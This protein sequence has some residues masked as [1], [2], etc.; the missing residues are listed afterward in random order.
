MG[1][2][3]FFAKLA[4]LD[5]EQR[6]KILWNLYWRG[7]AALRERI[8]GEL[9]PPERER[10]KRAVAAPPDPGLVLAEVSEFV[11]LASSGAYIA[12]DRRVSRTERSKWRVTFRR[13]ATEAQSALHAPDSD[14]AERAMELMIDLACDADGCFHSDNPLEAAKFVVSQAVSALWETV[15]DARG[16]AEFTARAVPQLIRWE[17]E[18]GWSNGDGKVMELERPLAEVLAS[19]LITPE[20]WSDFADAYLAELDRIAAAEAPLPGKGKKGRQSLAHSPYSA[21]SYARTRRTGD[22]AYWNSLLLEHLDEER[23]QRLAGHPAFGGTDADFLRAQAAQLRGD[24]DEARTLITKC[25]E[26]LPGSTQ[27]AEFAEEVGAEFPPRAREIHGRRRLTPSM[28]KCSGSSPSSSPSSSSGY[29]TG[30]S[31]SNA[32]QTG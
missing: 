28:S 3:E 24:L 15:L 29:S 5:A 19:M 32:T 11:E 22:L 31:P 16:F 9:D 17:R 7:T 13:L 30:E 25:L 26:T 8:E 18:C 10:R 23:A 21:E 1:R 4:P 12:G 14:L 20:M 27:Y 6:G 2:D